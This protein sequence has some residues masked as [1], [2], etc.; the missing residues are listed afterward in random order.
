MLERTPPQQFELVDPLV[1]AGKRYGLLDPLDEG[2][3]FHEREPWARGLQRL[4]SG[5]CRVEDVLN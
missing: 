1:Q 2:A 3:D 4:A 5:Q